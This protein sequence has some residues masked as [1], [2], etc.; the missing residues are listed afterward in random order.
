M[1]LFSHE[2][3]ITSERAWRRSDEERNTIYSNQFLNVGD[4]ITLDGIKWTVE[5]V[6]R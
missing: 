2:Y 4:I 1:K 5:E 6:I 3:I